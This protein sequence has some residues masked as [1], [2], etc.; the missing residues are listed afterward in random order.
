MFSA[1]SMLIWSGSMAMPTSNAPYHSGKKKGIAKVVEIKM[2]QQQ[3]DADRHQCFRFST[4][5][6][7]TLRPR[8]WRQRN[9]SVALARI[10]FANVDNPRGA[11]TEANHGDVI[12]GCCHSA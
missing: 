5:R 3:R 7:I 1:G 11:T 12:A 2:E 9:R 4:V 10:I 6:P 8:V